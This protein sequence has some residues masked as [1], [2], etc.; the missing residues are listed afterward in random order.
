MSHKRSTPTILF[1]TILALLTIACQF[2]ESTSLDT[3]GGPHSNFVPPRAIIQVDV[4]E[5]RPI[6]SYHISKNKLGAVEIFVNGQPVRAEETS[7][8]PTFPM[9][10]AAVQVL[11]RGR[12]APEAFTMLKFPAATCRILLKK[13][14]SVQTNSLP[15]KYPSSNWSVCHIW[16]GHIP[17]IYDLK[18]VATDKAG[19]EGKEIV[20]R[21][22]VK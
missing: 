15:L 17:G 2:F 7:G 4:G 20:Q 11:D 1:A 13:G 10:L 14:G 19:Q 9:E 22:E 18:V 8:Q 6:E 16:I 3:S 12:P 5:L 21:I